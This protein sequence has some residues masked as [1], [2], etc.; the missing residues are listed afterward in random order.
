MQPKNRRRPYEKESQEGPELERTTRIVLHESHGRVPQRTIGISGLIEGLGT[1]RCQGTSDYCDSCTET[2]AKF[3][4]SSSTKNF[5]FCALR[6][7]GGSIGK[8]C[9]HW[10]ATCHELRWCDDHVPSSFQE[11]ECLN[12][13]PLNPKPLTL[14]P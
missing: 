13:K 5:C 2:F 3:L 12:P 6:E 4:A 8:A 1:D 7:E 9:V 11:A 14:N 10:S